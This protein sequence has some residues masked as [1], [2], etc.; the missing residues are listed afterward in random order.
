[1]N[2][3]EGCRS[4]GAGVTVTE[5]AT[6]PCKDLQPDSLSHG[7]VL[8]SVTVGLVHLEQRDPALAERSEV[9]SQL[10]S[11]NTLM[12]AIDHCRRE[13]IRRFPET[14]SS[15]RRNVLRQV[16]LVA[17]LIHAAAGSLPVSD[18]KLRLLPSLSILLLT[19]VKDCRYGFARTL[20]SKS[21]MALSSPQVATVFP[22]VESAIDRTP[23]S[24]PTAV[25]SSALL[26]ASHNCSV[27]SKVTEMIRSASRM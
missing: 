24:V 17:A 20:S 6:W 7:H 21:L 4:S 22:S 14:A 5:S 3:V 9:Q 18:F 11:N 26:S 12:T 15:P 27:S 2:L 16:E 19:T 8:D 10:T 13:F 1:M 25:A 23:L